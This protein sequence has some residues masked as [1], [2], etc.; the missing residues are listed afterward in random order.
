MAGN[1][2]EWFGPL[3]T[4]ANRWTRYIRNLDSLRTQQLRFHGA[5]TDTEYI[6]R[7]TELGTSP[8]GVFGAKLHLEHITEAKRRLRGHLGLPT[9]SLVAALQNTFPNLQLIWLRRKDKIAQ[10]ISLHRAIES[11]RFVKGG[12]DVQVRDGLPD[13]ACR[14]DVNAI[15]RHVDTLVG[16]DTAWGLIFER[17]QIKPLEIEYEQFVAD[18]RA[19]ILAVLDFISVDRI[20]DDIRP[21][22][23]RQADA[24]SAEWHRRFCSTFQFNASDSADMLRPW[25]DGLLN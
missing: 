11:G 7:V 24:V 21:V 17:I 15:Q 12:G 2:E 22:T 25:I 8:N 20:S 14:F 4:R 5:T 13:S 23:E 9:V 18:Y 3:A 16:E 10:A 19:T 6:R 1:P